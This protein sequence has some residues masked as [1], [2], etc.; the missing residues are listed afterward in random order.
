MGMGICGW[1]YGDGNMGMGICGTWFEE[2]SLGFVLGRII[3]LATVR[4]RVRSR[5]TRWG[6][7]RVG[8]GARVP[9]GCR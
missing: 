1:E 2:S 8:G 5:G 7:A 6:G 3:V 9:I 4:A